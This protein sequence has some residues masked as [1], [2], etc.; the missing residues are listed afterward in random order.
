MVEVKINERGLQ[1]QFQRYEKTIGDFRPFFDNEGRNI[2]QSEFQRAFETRG[3]G[4][5]APLRERT[6]SNKRRLGQPSDPL[7]ATGELKRSL[8]SLEGIVRT[9]FTLTFRSPVPYSIYHELG[10]QRMPA[11]PVF[12]TIVEDGRRK[13]AV[14]LRR[15]LQK[16][17]L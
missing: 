2:L 9:K 1:R 16:R 5:W 3:F 15:Y 6:L 14:G 4:Q 13:F 11:R 17:F 8:T 12:R 7:V 10:T